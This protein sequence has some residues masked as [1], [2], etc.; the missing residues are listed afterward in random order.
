MGVRPFWMGIEGSICPPFPSRILL[1]SH[2]PGGLVTCSM[3]LCTSCSHPSPSSRGPPSLSPLLSLPFQIRQKSRGGL[4]SPEKTSAPDGAWVCRVRLGNLGRF[5]V[6]RLGDRMGPPARLGRAH[7]LARWLGDISC[8][9]LG[10][11]TPLSRTG[12]ESLSGVFFSYIGPEQTST[13]TLPCSSQPCMTKKKV[14]G[15]SRSIGR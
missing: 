6:S 15:L 8:V 10:P 11:S 14:E 4:K 13:G 12:K 2:F 9:K 7:V 5:L 1:F 3:C